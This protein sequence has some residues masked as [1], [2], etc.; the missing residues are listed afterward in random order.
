M[1]HAT[2]LQTYRLNRKRGYSPQASAVSTISEWAETVTVA[3]DRTNRVRKVC[4]PGRTVF[5]PRS[6]GH[7]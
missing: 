3:R 1:T 2:P 4:P 6:Y 7:G 5:D